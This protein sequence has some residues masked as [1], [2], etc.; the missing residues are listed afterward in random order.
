MYIRERYLIK[1]LIAKN[2]GEYY[3]DEILASRNACKV[4]VKSL[5]EI[6]SQSK[7]IRNKVAKYR[8]RDT[9]IPFSLTKGYDQTLYRESIKHSIFTF[10]ST[11]FPNC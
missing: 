10:A 11:N 2:E 9:V 1:V 7:S 4:G 8:P 5:F 6:E 3:S